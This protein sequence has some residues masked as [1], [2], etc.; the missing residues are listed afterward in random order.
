MKKHAAITVLLFVALALR[1]TWGFIHGDK[2]D[3]SLPDQ[4][5]Y[6]EL[7]Q[8]LRNGYGLNFYDG[9]FYQSVYAY[10]MPGYPLFA[11]IGNSVH[12]VLFHQAI[13]DTSTVFA[14]YLLARRW[15]NKGPSL[16]AAAAVAFNPFMIYFSALLL[17]ETLYTTL[18]LW[19]CVLLVWQPNFLWGGIVLALSVLVRPSA[20][21]LPVLLGIVSVFVNYTP[22][23]IEGKKRWL[24]LPVGTT[25]LLLVILVLFPWAVRNKT[26]IGQWVWLTTN[27][28]ATR[29]DGFNPDA[30]GAS[31]QQ[32]LSQ[33]QMRFLQH[34]SE[35]ERDEY[36][37]QQAN[38]WISETW[39]REPSRLFK[40]TFAKIARTWSPVP[41]SAEYGSRLLYKLAAAAYSIPILILSVVGLWAAFLPRSARLFLLSPIVYFTMIHA[42]SVGSLRYRVPLE[43]LLAILAAAGLMTISDRI[44][45]RRISGQAG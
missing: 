23:L 27:G 5:E 20:A 2:I 45:R 35:V 8:N 36:L 26:K 3:P 41:L 14:T 4:Q 44:Q 34:M 42:V 29:Y 40:L 7:S 43:P 22:G 6:L 39:Q 28:G 18:L 10:R 37:S 15:L 25:M 38:K 17:S 21:L 11:S 33:P 1:L 31:N 24:R 32:F 30:T 9:R 16:L 19:G 13:F 12:S